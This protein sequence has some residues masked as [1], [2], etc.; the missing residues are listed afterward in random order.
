MFSSQTYKQRRDTLRGMLSGGV[1]LFVGSVDA[2]ANA[3]SNTY[4]YRQNSNFLYYF[5]LDMPDLVAVVDVESGEDIIFGNDLT[6]SD[7]IWTGPQPTIAELAARVGVTITKPLSELPEYIARAQA[8][9]RKIHANCRNTDCTERNRGY[10]FGGV[11][12]RIC[13]YA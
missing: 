6:I 13:G 2:P 1:A 5:G 3:L 8:Q 12:T 11:G 4:R 10:P 7:L 9:G